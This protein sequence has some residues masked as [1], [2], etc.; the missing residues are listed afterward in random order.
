MPTGTTLASTIG[1]KMDIRF[2]M[3]TKYVG[4]GDLELYSH[5]RQKFPQEAVEYQQ[6][7]WLIRNGI[8]LSQSVDDFLDLHRSND[9]VNRYGKAAIVKAVLEA[10]R[11]S[12][13]YFNASSG[14]ET[15]NP[16]GCANTWFVKFMHALGRGIPKENV[17]EVFDHVAFIVFNYDRCIEHFLLHS[18]QKLYGI[19]QQEASEILSNLHVIHPYGTIGEI[20]RLPF[21]GSGDQLRADY[22]TLSDR[23]K[24]YTEQIGASDL[25]GNLQEEVQRADCIVF[26][27]FAYHSQNMRLLRPPTAMRQKSVFGTAYGMSDADTDVI[28]HQIAEFFTPNMTSKT[29]S[30]VIR[31]ERNLTGAGLFD[32]YTKSLTGGD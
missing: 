10:E 18:L 22:V 27:G 5:I 11:K 15:F 32:N 24:T 21:G 30:L 29:R 3:L 16:D 20:E 25:L 9:R 8:T 31:L 4:S 6:A 23:I 26:L 12:K 28:S 19:P 2:E 1:K 17:R 14:V 7:G 13:L